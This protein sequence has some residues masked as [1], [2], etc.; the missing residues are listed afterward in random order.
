MKYPLLVAAICLSLA[1]CSEKEP[2]KAAAPVA[3][4]VATAASGFAKATAVRPA[5]IQSTLSLPNACALDVVN[6]Q[7]AK[8]ALI[9]DKAR[10]KLHGWAG[11]VPAG[12]SPKQVVIELEGPSKVYV[13]TALGIKRPDVADAFKKPGLADTGWIAYADLS[14]AAAGTY[15]VHIIQ[16]EGHSG[17]VCDSNKS[18][19]IK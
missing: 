4:P 12:T 8:D 10:V 19:A 1:A 15:K 7:P 18:I 9:S 3:P 14:E 6:D 17:L 11:N 16:V 13:E 2:E 5:V